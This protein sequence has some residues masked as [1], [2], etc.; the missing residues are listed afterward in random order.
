MAYKF[1]VASEQTEKDRS[2]IIDLKL[3][4]DKKTEIYVIL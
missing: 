1:T 3:S 4:V 2:A